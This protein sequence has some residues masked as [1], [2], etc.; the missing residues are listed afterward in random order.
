LYK[1]HVYYGGKGEAIYEENGN[2]E[3][4]RQKKGNLD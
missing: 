3:I 2:F 1:Y 4:N